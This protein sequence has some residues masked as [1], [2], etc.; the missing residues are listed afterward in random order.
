MDVAILGL[1]IGGVGI[2]PDDTAVGGAVA[3]LS[4]LVEVLPAGEEAGEGDDLG[5][6]LNIAARSSESDCMK[7]CSFSCNCSTVNGK[8]AT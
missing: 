8:S 2:D 7:A 4:P 1:S 3:A 6:E 5:S